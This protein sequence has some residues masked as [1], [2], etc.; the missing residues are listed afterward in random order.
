MRCRLPAPRC[1]VGEREQPPG[2]DRLALALGG[3][4]FGGRGLDRARNETV[5]QLA[6]QD[7]ARRRC[8]LEPGRGVDGVAGD[9]RLAARVIACDDL[10][11]VHAHAHRELDPQFVAQRATELR[12]AGRQIERAAHSPQGIVLVRDRQ[13]EDAH[14]RIADELLDLSSV[15][16][17]RTR[18]GGEIALLDVAQHLRV[19]TLTERGRP[20]QV[21]EH[22]R[23]LGAALARAGLAQRVA[24]ARAE[25][26][27]DR[28]E[29]ATPRTWSRAWQSRARIPA[30][31]GARR[32]G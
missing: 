23:D 32:G 26:R 19:E 17:E 29:R 31:T 9:E 12:D 5:R 25:E 6:D 30:P 14:D 10:A 11:R 20:G 24:A 21:A 22:D 1:L 28:L 15:S 27:F 3:D 18:G 2:R 13:P 7:A 8:L 16:L 4:R